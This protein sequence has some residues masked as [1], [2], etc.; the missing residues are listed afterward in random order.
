MLGLL[1]IEPRF[2][3]L[4]QHPKEWLTYIRHSH[5]DLDVERD[6]CR[7]HDDNQR[8]ACQHR[9]QDPTHSLAH[10]GVHHTDFTI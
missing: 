3:L 5:N 6:G 2:L 8:L 10:D 4:Q 1:S 7:G 9:E